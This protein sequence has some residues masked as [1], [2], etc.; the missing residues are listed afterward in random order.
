M[1]R[2]IRFGD[3]LADLDGLEHGAGFVL[4]IDNGLIGMLEGYSNTGEAW[5]DTPCNFELRYWTR[6]RDLTPFLD[7]SDR[8]E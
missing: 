4:F 3:V 5:P 6:P 7:V 2:G 8:S 1:S